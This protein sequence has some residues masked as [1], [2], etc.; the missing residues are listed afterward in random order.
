MGKLSFNFVI[1]T[2]HIVKQV[3]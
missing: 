2:P 3:S 1:R